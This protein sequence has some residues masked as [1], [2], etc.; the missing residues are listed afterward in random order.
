MLP[1][2]VRN[3][4]KSLKLRRAVPG[5]IRA[6]VCIGGAIGVDDVAAGKRERRE[7]EGCRDGE[8]AGERKREEERQ[9]QGAGGGI[10]FL[11]QRSSWQPQPKRS[12][13]Q[14]GKGSWGRNEPVRVNDEL[15]DLGSSSRYRPISH[16]E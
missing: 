4:C 2:R 1:W 8:G 10:R 5:L 7:V 16:L 6:V 14:R 13:E 3:C 11:W 9:K 12:S 15:T